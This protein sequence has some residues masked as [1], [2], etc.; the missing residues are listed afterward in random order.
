MYKI[1][2]S[3]SRIRSGGEFALFDCAW[4]LLQGSRISNKQSTTKTAAKPNFPLYFRP[5]LELLYSHSLLLSAICESPFYSSNFYIL[6]MAETSGTCPLFPPRNLF[7]LAGLPAS[8]Q[9]VAKVTDNPPSC[10]SPASLLRHPS[11]K[12]T[13]G[14]HCL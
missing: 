12:K 6:I 13:R 14:P 11:W 9:W 1:Y 5:H 8:P 2:L 4:K 10:R 7:C 3:I